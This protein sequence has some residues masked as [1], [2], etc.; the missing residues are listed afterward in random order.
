MLLQNGLGDGQ[1]QPGAGASR[2]LPGAVVPVKEV[3]QVL[4][5]DAGAVV[6]HLHPAAAALHGDG[7]QDEHPVRPQMPRGVA[8]QIVQHPLHH[9]GVRLHGALPVGLQ[10]QRPAV[11]LT[12]RVVAPGHLK[13]Q[14]THVEL[15]QIG[16]VRAALHLAQLHHAVHQRREP[17]GLVHNDV[18]LLGAF[19]LVIAVDVPHRL[20]IALDEGQ[21]GAQVVAHV[22][23]DVLFQLGRAAHL[24]GHVVEFL[25]QQPEFVRA[26]NVH[27]Y[28]IVAVRHLP[29]ALCQKMQRPGIPPAEQHRKQQ[30]EQQ[31]EQ[32]DGGQDLRQHPRSGG[33]LGEVRGYDDPVISVLRQ[34]AHHHLPG[35]AGVHDLIDAALLKQRFAQTD[36]GG[37][38]PRQRQVA[39]KGAHRLMEHAGVQALVIL[40]VAAGG[41][42]DVHTAVVHIELSA[43]NGL[44]QPAPEFLV[45]IQ[46]AEPPCRDR[47]VGFV[48]HGGQQLGFG[49][50]RSAD[51]GVV[52]GLK[53][54]GHHD[55]DEQ[56]REQR[57]AADEQHQL[58]LHAQKGAG[59]LFFL[60]DDR[61]T[62]YPG[63]TCSRCPIPSR[64]SR[65]RDRD[66]CAAF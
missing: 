44:P 17:V 29:G 11:L 2:I 40:H 19:F 30:V 47:L 64:C 41:V 20:G 55:P 10:P 66:G 8:Q 33:D 61:L 21:R 12:Q 9:G 37:G 24:P 14:L 16:L 1:P 7:P 49:G 13:A 46:R 53:P 15:H 22:G 60:Q 3:G 50:E 31:Q 35:G 63:R 42:A 52:L 65:G 28:I 27:L 39:A 36:G 25:R 43:L 48:Q 18:A 56:Q 26:V 57:D 5:R 59:A 54:A 51:G 23:K 34:D 62:G 38:V 45:Q 6:L 32:C 58:P 4:R